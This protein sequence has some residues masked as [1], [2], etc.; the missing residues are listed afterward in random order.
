VLADDVFPLD[1]GCVCGHIRYRMTQRPLI[2]HCCHCHWC[3]RES[4]ASFALNALIEADFAPQLTGDPQ[5]V[6][7]PSQSGLGQLIARCPVCRV[8]VWS[9]YGGAGPVIRFIR[10]G[11]LD[12]PNH[13][14]PDIHIYT[15]FKQPWVII[16]PQ[17]AAVPEYYERAQYWSAESL[18]RRVLILPR[19]E[20]H[21]EAT[22]T[23]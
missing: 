3:Q 12:A 21:R 1:G 7:T 6:S 5:L 17:A 2:V 8:A 4:G 9:N 18:A 20:A 19:I 14:P 10:V 15:A 22:R 23:R 16:P 11:T 13:L